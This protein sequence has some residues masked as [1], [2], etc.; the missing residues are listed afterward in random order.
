M[1]QLSEQYKI[2]KKY[3]AVVKGIYYVI[4][5]KISDDDSCIVFSAF[6]TNQMGIICKMDVNTKDVICLN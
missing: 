2:T 5:T 3:I 6:N 1:Y 4:Y